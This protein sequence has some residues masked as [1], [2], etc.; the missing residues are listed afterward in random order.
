MKA[1]MEGGTFWTL[2]SLLCKDLLG[3]LSFFQKLAGR[4]GKRPLYY[5]NTGISP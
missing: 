3:M 2:L 4:K 5:V 1:E